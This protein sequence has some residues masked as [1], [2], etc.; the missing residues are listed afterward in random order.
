MRAAA[1]PPILVFIM[2]VV[3]MCCVLA[4]SEIKADPE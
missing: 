4:C 1:L 2:A 3:S